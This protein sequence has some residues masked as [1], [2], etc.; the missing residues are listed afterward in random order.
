MEFASK[1]YKKRNNKKFAKSK[2]LEK[3]ECLERYC[4]VQRFGAYINDSD[5]LLKKK[6]APIQRKICIG[7]RA[8]C[9]FT[10]LDNDA[11][12][13]DAFL[14]AF[15]DIRSPSSGYLANSKLADNLDFY[16]WN[17]TSFS[18]PNFQQLFY[19]CLPQVYG[20]LQYTPA[21]VY[22]NMAPVPID[23]T[24]Y[25]KVDFA[26]ANKKIGLTATPKNYTWHHIEGIRVNSEK[27]ECDM[28]LLKSDYHNAIWHVGSVNQYEII[29]NTDYK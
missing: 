6:A 25:R 3:M 16:L 15:A 4:P 2:T 17:D 27:I 29:K 9:N 28:I 12:F 13:I 18:F 21:V 26:I 19:T 5:E 23:M 22:E 24:G 8:Y 1:T 14:S 10:D 11:Q 20:Y 7:G